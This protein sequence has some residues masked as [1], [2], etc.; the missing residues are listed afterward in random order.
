M[1]L[2]SQLVHGCEFF[3]PVLFL[4]GYLRQLCR[5]WFGCWGGTLC[6]SHWCWVWWWVCLGGA[7]LQVLLLL[8]VLPLVLCLGGG[9][10][11]GV[12]FCI[13]FHHRIS[14]G[15][16]SGPC[17][18]SAGCCLIIGWSGFVVAAVTMRAGLW[19]LAG[20]F[21]RPPNIVGSTTFPRSHKEGGLSTLACTCWCRTT[22]SPPCT[23]ILW[24]KCRLGCRGSNILALFVVM[25]SEGG[26]PHHHLQKQ[27]FCHLVMGVLIIFPRV[28]GHPWYQLYVRSVHCP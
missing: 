3:P 7:S 1:V 12:A 8:Q 16:C 22:I 24:C 19:L 28:D 11:A 9:F 21:R 18:V 10:L 17:G 14:Q 4:W 2:S 6:H 23:C 5:G 20:S 15:P 27:N 25:H 13:S 26:G